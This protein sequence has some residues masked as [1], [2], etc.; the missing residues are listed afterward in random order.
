MTVKF[1]VSFE[2]LMNRGLEKNN[3]GGRLIKWRDQRRIQ[4]LKKRGHKRGCGGFEKERP[5]AGAPEAQGVWGKSPQPST[6][7]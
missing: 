4:D 1:G 3:E 2:L 7:F 6:N 5:Q